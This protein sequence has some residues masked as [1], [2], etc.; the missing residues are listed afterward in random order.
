MK[1]LKLVICLIVFVA[2]NSS[3]SQDKNWPEMAKK[4]VNETANVKPGDVVIINGG[5]HT[6]PLMEQIAVESYRAGAHPQMMVSSDLALKA[7]WFDM[8]E[9]N[10]ADY[11]GFTVE[12][13]K[14]ADIIINL[15]ASENSQKIFKDVDPK[16]VA[17]A[18]SNSE[19]IL[20]AISDET[21]YSSIAISYPTK[22]IAE[23]SGIDFKEYEKMHWAAVNTNSNNLSVAGTQII[24]MLKNAKKVKITTKDGTNISFSMGDRYVFADDGILTEDEKNNDVW[25][26]RYA[27]L[28]GGW[29]DFAPME[30]TVNGKVVVARSR[31][32]YELFTGI[33]F[34][35]KNGVISNFKADKGADCYQKAMDPHTGNKHM[36]SV[37]T[38]GLNPEL[39]IIQ[40]GP[41]DYR[42][43]QAAGYM[44]LSIGGNNSQYNGNVKSTGG[45]SFPLVNPT[46]EIDGTI[47][48][49]EG[50][51]NL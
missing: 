48:I 34:S 21:K 3:F 30:S 28:P 14:E 6:L 18:S 43:T 22:Q 25:F 29:M 9:K 1:K 24:G 32:N 36:V 10:L 15:P 19:K 35:V 5:M 49:K 46:L 23:V 17:I 7:F 31:C 37:F 45:Y 38:L 27:S 2:I 20:Q 47:V 42:N 39:K 4:I 11:N 41:T 16:R 40:D 44:T 12:W 26:A 50:K 33:S 8:P 51:I 13:N